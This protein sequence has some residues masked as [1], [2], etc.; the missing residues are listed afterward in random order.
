MCT[1]QPAVIVHFR[2]FVNALL[3]A[4]V[5]VTSGSPPAAAG[6]DSAPIAV[7]PRTSSPAASPLSVGMGRAY[8][9]FLEL[10]VALVLGVMWFL[11]VALMGSCAFLL[12]LAVSALI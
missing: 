12:Y 6:Q 2:S 8:P 7:R 3:E 5:N 9:R 11:G 4:T 10:P 1:V